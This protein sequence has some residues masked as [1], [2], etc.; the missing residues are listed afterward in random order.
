MNNA[1]PEQQKS[2]IAPRCN[3]RKIGP[4]P[5]MIKHKRRF[6][7]LLLVLV[8]ALSALL[9]SGCGGSKPYEAA[10]NW[11]VVTIDPEAKTIT[12][13]N[14]VYTY[15]IS[16]SR[17]VTTTTLS[18]P[19]GATYYLSSY[20]INS[21]SGW[22]DDYDENRYIPGDVLISLLEREYPQ[23]KKGTPFLGLVCVA[24]GIWGIAKPESLWYLGYGWRYRNAEPSDAAL[25]MERLSGGLGI[26]VGLLLIFL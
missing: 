1:L 6:A 3:L 9:L 26:V 25:V 20:G 17:T 2:Y 22:S 19:N 11:G 7:V 8:L 14:D 10:T 15:E 12:R 18:Y 21:N 13:G 23:E 5:V 16:I 4:D 24:L